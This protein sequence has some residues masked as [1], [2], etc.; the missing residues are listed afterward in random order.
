MVNR[1]SRVLASAAFAGLLAGSLLLAP[2]GCNRTKEETKYS[3]EVTNPNGTKSEVDVKK[4][5]TQDN[6]GETKTKV[7]TKVKPS[8]P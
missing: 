6:N 1:V 5:T 3:H 4:K 2:T 7:E 8:Q